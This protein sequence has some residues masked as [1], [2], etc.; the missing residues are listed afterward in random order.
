MSHYFLQST[1][2]G[3]SYCS[4][5]G[6]LKY[7]NTPSKNIFSIDNNYNILNIDPLIVK[8]KPISLNLDTSL[9]AHENYLKFR[10]RGLTKIYSLSNNFNLGK[11]IIFK[12]IGAMDEIYLNNENVPLENIEI[13]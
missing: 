13:I 11:N 6:C 7:K 12:A 9:I 1:K 8:Y 2:Q 4:F 5:C 3:V 10:Q